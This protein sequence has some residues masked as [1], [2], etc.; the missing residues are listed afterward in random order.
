VETI[1]LAEQAAELIPS[2]RELFVVR[3][4][5]LN[6]CDCAIHKTQSAQSIEQ[7]QG[8]GMR[9]AMRV[10]DGIGPL[11]FVRARTAGLSDR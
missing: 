2:G 5:V 3:Q 4:D 9:L 11:G 7:F 1:D 8:D 10:H 6:A